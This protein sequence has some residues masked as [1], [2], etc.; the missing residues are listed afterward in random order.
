RDSAER[1]SW[2]RALEGTVQ[3]V[4]GYYKFR[5]KNSVSNLP[6]IQKSCQEFDRR[7]S[8]ADAYLQLILDNIKNQF[9]PG[10]SIVLQSMTTSTTQSD[11]KNENLRT[12]SLSTVAPANRVHLH[13]TIRSYSSSDEEESDEIFFDTLDTD[14]DT[15]NVKND[16]V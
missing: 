16:D 3:R 5:G 8:E 13:A 4:S 7:I 11:I 1:E 12:A 9:C 10:E 2:I 6:S 15:L 14:H